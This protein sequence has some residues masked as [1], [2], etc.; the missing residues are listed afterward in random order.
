MTFKFYIP[1]GGNHISN[2]YITVTAEVEDGQSGQKFNFRTPLKI[3]PNHWDSKKQRPDNIYLKKY[4]LINSRLDKLKIGLSEYIK[5]KS[6]EKKDISQKMIYREIKRICARKETTYPERS[7]LL[8]MIQ[9]INSKKGFISHSTYKR[10]MVFFRMVEKFEG[11]AGERIYI[12]SIDSSILNQ[13]I[14]FG[15]KEMYSENTIHR[16]I[17]F[18][19]TILNFAEKKGIRTTVRQLDIK[20]KKQHRVIVSLSEEEISAIKKVPLS[21]ELEPARDW[22]LISCYTG[23]RIS[24]FME[25]TT[26][27]LRK[28]DGRTYISFTQKKTNK[29]ILLPL[30]PQVISILKKN[31]NNFPPR[32]T[33]SQYNLYIKQIAMKAGITQLVMARK[34]KGHRARSSLVQKWEV[35]SSHIGRR[36]FATIFY[37]KIPTPLLMEATGHSTEKMFL[38][39]INSADMNRA[40]SLSNYFQQ[41]EFEN[42]NEADPAKQNE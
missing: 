8:F 27:Q 6:S 36:S 20:R 42:G 24:D 23:Q 25:F 13:F 32:Y 2:I 1:K 29:N 28:I 12:D 16:T 9:Y 5:K 39:Y 31:G 26:D 14:K 34:R 35:L 7:L 4:K 10:Y 37:G 15:K 18:I 19:R 11:F 3:D 38:Q 17:H 41:I 21:K 40:I 22:L 33:P 30:H